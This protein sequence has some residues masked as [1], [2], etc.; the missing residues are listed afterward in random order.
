MKPIQLTLISHLTDS[1]QAYQH[2]QIVLQAKDGV[3]SPEDIKGLEL[4]DGIQW[5]RGV[6]LE[7][8]APIW[9]YGYLIHLCHPAAWVGCYDPRLSG[10]VVVQTH[11]QGVSVGS[12]IPLSLPD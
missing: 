5:S 11:T 8:R 3:I 10:A 1:G 4:P 2:L 6:V 7:G 12:V 9:L